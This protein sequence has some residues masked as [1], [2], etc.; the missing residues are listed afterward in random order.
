MLPTRDCA[1]VVADGR[2]RRRQLVAELRQALLGGHVSPF[3]WGQ[4]SLPRAATGH[5]P[6]MC[7][8]RCTAISSCMF[9]TPQAWFGITVTTSPISGR[10]AQPEKSTW[11]CSSES[12]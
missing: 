8:L 6:T 12:A 4:R 9:V 11:P 1:D 10:L 7:P 2:V 3:V 5:E